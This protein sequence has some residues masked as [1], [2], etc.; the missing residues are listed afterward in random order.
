[1]KPLYKQIRDYRKSKGITQVHI[2]KVTGINNKRLSFIENGDVELRAEELIL[3]VEK[4]FG[5]DLTSFLQIAS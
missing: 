5:L 1:M 3:I 4:G 2:A